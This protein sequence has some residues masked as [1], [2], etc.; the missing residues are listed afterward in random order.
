MIQRRLL[1]KDPPAAFEEDGDRLIE[2]KRAFDTLPPK[3]RAV[4]VLRL[5]SG[6]S[7]SDTAA[8]L[9]C[10]VGAVKSQLHL[11]RRRLAI[12]LSDHDDVRESREDD[13]DR[14]L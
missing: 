9:G 5:F 2:L 8:A 1:Y 12:E 14:A 6:L 13:H 4:A 11:A 10:S 3:M 7:E